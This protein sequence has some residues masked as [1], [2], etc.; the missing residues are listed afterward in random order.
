MCQ[1]KLDLYKDF[2]CDLVL[3]INETFLGDHLMGDKEKGEHFDWC[4]N[5]VI[6]EF[7][8]QEI[9]FGNECELKDFMWDSFYHLFYKSEQNKD[10]VKDNL[11]IMWT[12]VFD[13]RLEKGDEEAKFAINAYNKFDNCLNR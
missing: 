7:A 4:W 3:K 12:F 1:E 8:E 9:Y 13:Y 6:E 11:L 5:K 2:A 10:E